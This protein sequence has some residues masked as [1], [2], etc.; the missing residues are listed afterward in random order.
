MEEIQL[1][2]PGTEPPVDKLSTLVQ[3]AQRM[4]E[5]FLAIA[6]AEEAIQALKEFNKD[7]EERQ[8]P[9]LMQEIGL[10]EITLRSGRRIATIREYYPNVSKE[11]QDAA[12]SWLRDHNMGGIIKTGLLV[13][14]RSEKLLSDQNIPF[15]KK[16]TIHP[17]TLKA[18]IREQCELPNSTFP[19]DVFGVF[20]MTRAV[21]KAAR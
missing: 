6:Q 7:L 20:E 21:V 11:R 16:E 17:G 15:E 19:K 2:L 9:D 14:A 1:P 10:T 4:E 12:Y 8:L 13:D 3:L 18:L 5:G